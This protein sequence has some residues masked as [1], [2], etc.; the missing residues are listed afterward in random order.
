MLIYDVL[1]KE[2]VYEIV[3]ND[4]RNIGKSITLKRMRLKQINLKEIKIFQRKS[5]EHLY[6][7]NR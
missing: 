5:S 7:I 6:H 1:H 2:K 4:F 3:I